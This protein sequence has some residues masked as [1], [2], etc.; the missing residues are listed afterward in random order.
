MEMKQ[1]AARVAHGFPVRLILIP[2]YR[3]EG[4]AELTREGL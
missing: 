1:S 4:T 2:W 3:V